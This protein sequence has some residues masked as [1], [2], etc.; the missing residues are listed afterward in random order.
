MKGR[1]GPQRPLFFRLFPLMITHLTQG[2]L[3]TLP[4]TIGV[5]QV[6]DFLSRVAPAT[7][8][9]DAPASV[10]EQTVGR[11][12]GLL[13]ASFC[14][15]QLLTSFPLGRLSDRIGRRPIV[16]AGNAACAATVLWFGLASTYASAVSSRV[17]GG[18]FNAV[19]G[20]EK[21]IIGESLARDEQA[22]AMGLL[23][24]MWGVGSLLGP[25]VGALAK[26]CDG[27]MLAG[28]GVCGTE[29]LF[30]LHPYLL[31]CVLASSLCAAALVLT[32][33]LLDETLPRLR[34]G[35]AIAGETSS[36]SAV[37]LE[38]EEG[39][40][41]NSGGKLGAKTLEMVSFGNR[42]SS[43]DVESQG[44]TGKSCPGPDEPWF[45]QKNV[46]LALGGYGLIAFVYSL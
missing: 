28:S 41:D 38:E 9:A 40:N 36:Y 27:G 4:F 25:G 39:G 45:K 18:F 20:A 11:L 31:P 17:V 21:S 14:A 3:V 26:P 42:K 32:W 7:A 12:V 22:K 23:S 29:G 44:A 16:L 33:T 34:S 30:A 6:R 43:A 8:G 5:Y 10:D 24:L 13:G 1:E 37:P 46:V 19:I 35:G 2:L 15:A